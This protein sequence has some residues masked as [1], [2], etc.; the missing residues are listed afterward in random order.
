MGFRIPDWI[1]KE[2][3]LRQDATVNDGAENAKPIQ[4]WMG[5]NDLLPFGQATF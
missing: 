4:G 3:C 1:P 2:G 5:G